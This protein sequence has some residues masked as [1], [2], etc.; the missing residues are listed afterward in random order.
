MSRDDSDLANMMESNPTVSG[1]RNGLKGRFRRA[2]SFN[3]ANTLRE[4]EEGAEDPITPRGKANQGRPGVLVDN[5][6][7]D[8]AAAGAKKKSRT[9]LFNSKLNAS[10]D[11]IS[12]SSTMS[13]ASMVIRKLGKMANLTRRNSLAGITSLFK[14]KKDKEDDAN[15]SKKK[16][17]GGKGA[18]AEASVSHVT[19][20]LDRS[21]WSAELNGL[22][23]AARLARQ[24]TLKTNAEAAARASM[25]QESPADGATPATW[26][27]NTT[28]RKDEANGR[29]SEVGTRV[30]VEQ[31]SDSDEDKSEGPSH[32][33]DVS[34]DGWDDNED[35]GEGDDDEDVTV[36]GVGSL[37]LDRDDDMEPWA[38]DLRRS[39]EKK[40]TPAKGI[41]KSERL[42]L[43]RSKFSLLT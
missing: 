37:Q 38:V 28:T 5:S 19:A 23:P 12:L 34:L 1:S 10:T 13:S 9:A 35:W 36:R 29:V 31:D 26:E 18:A 15:K 4:E 8:P 22:T 42:L 7:D 27:K 24:H 2:I 40:R 16:K 41:L 39:V 11:N 20:E 43:L 32:T 3:A 30:V 21:E 17:K 14:E 25:I 6:G 33:Q